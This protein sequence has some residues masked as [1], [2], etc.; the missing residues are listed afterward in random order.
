VDSRG[1]EHQRRHRLVQIAVSWNPF[2]LITVT[3][4]GT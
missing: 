4:A 3:E 2:S 1:T